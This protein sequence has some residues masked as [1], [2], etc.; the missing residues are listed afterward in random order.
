MYRPGEKALLKVQAQ[1]K[2]TDKKIREA[3]DNLAHERK[4]LA[5][6]ILAL[7]RLDRLPPQA[8][9]ARPSAPIDTARSIT[10][11]AKCSP[12]DCRK[13]RRSKNGSR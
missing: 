12:Q 9:L 11:V 8:L 2:K 6:M 1:Q 10:L 13:S 3:K 7:R 4:S 5:Q